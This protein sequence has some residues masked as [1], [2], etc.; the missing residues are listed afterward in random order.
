MDLPQGLGDMQEKDRR[1]VSRSVGRDMEFD[2][3]G[4]HVREYNGKNKVADIL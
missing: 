2:A 3:V 4:L 1:S